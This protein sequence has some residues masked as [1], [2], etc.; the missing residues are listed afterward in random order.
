M[1][2]RPSSVVIGPDSNIICADKFGD[3]Y[4][5]PLIPEAIPEG[6]RLS[7]SSTPAKLMTKPAASTLTVHS[8]KNL[9]A[10]KHQQQQ[11]EERLAKGLDLDSADGPDFEFKLLLGHV[12]MLTSIAVAESE[13]RRYILTSDR[14]EHIRLSRYIPQAH[15]IEGF[16]FGHKEF[17]STMVIPPAKGDLL[18]SGGGDPELFIWDWKAGS[19]LSKTSILPLAQAVDPE[20]TKVAVSGL[21]TLQ[22]PAESGDLTYVLAICEE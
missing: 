7:K 8:K 6:E 21:Y 2:K 19:L 15:I 3:V 17:I 13:G 12:S 1:P 9:M 10:L 16:C 20:V 4:A 14:D 11:I 22:Y 18:V 5:L